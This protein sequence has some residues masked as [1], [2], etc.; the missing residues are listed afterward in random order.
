MKLRKWKPAQKA[1][2]VLEGFKGT[3]RPCA[4]EAETVT[5][6]VLEAAFD[7]AYGEEQR[8]ADRGGEWPQHE[9]A[10]DRENCQDHQAD[11]ALDPVLGFHGSTGV[12]SRLEGSRG[13]QVSP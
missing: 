8:E 7:E 13:T 10:A 6:T 12:P 4:R 2:I 11:R 1:L 3:L 5:L 9:H